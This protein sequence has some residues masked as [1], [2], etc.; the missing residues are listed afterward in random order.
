MRTRRFADSELIRG[1]ERRLLEVLRRQESARLFSMLPKGVIGPFTHSTP[2]G[3]NSSTINAPLL[4]LVDTAAETWVVD[5]AAVPD[6]TGGFADVTIEAGR[7]IGELAANTAL[8]FSGLPAGSY[9]IYATHDPKDEN[10][11]TRQPP[12][13]Y[14]AG[15]GSF[16]E[17]RSFFGHSQSDGVPIPRES[18]DNTL[19]PTVVSER[20]D[21]VALAIAP[22][23]AVPS[24]G[25]ILLRI[26][27]NGSM[28]VA[29]TD[30]S[31]RVDLSD[32]YNHIGS[33]GAA[34][35][36]ATIGSA[37]FMSSSDKTRLET[38]TEL[39]TGST[40]VLR[41]ASGRFRAADPVAAMD[42][43][44]KQYVDSLAGGVGAHNHDNR[45]VRYDAAQSLTSSQTAQIRT[46]IGAAAA[47]HDH[48]SLYYDKATVTSLVNGRLAV[49]ATAADSSKLNGLTE[50]NFLRT[51]ASRAVLS[52]TTITFNSG[53]ALVVN[54][55]L[56][57][58]V[59]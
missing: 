58:P 4:V 47:S 31:L 45:Y 34:H 21:R 14:A 38:A 54:G 56:R 41:D 40:L 59:K 18:Y 33:G 24:N 19:A 36:L 30:A 57:I 51:N 42:V 26:G 12:G 7:Q 5:Q 43:A 48:N 13:K 52:G 15:T 32:L 20:V 28:V 29:V 49:G 27:W 3:S 1:K 16:A 23:T 55:T 10:P 9:A 8:S 22:A 44:T 35:A 11:E 17:H 2:V 6:P 37:G 25:T 39:Q 53:S 46:N 50:S